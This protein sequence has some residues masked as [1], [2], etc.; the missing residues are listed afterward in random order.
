MLGGISVL[1]KTLLSSSVLVVV[2]S[3]G[4]E[5]WDWDDWGRTAWAKLRSA[6][7][8]CLACKDRVKRRC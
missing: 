3:S 2:P 7:R 5:M 8:S 6:Q 1:A 4:R